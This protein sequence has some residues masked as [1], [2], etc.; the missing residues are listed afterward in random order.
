MSDEKAPRSGVA[1]AVK[2]ALLVF[3]IVVGGVAVTALLAGDQNL[4][5]FDYG[6]F[7]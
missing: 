3:G 5:P 4:L 1:R 7:D 6:G 2:I